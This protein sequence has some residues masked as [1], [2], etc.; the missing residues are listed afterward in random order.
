MP[1]SSR[2]ILAI[3][4]ATS[5]DFDI[6]EFLVEE[7]A[8]SEAPFDDEEAMAEVIGEHLVK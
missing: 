3:S 8:H 5:L 4:N 7:L 2:A 1:L 6:C